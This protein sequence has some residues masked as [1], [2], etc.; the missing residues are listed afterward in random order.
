M[1]N[2]KNIMMSSNQKVWFITGSNKGIGAAIVK[3]Y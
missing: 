3:R 2:L 1:F